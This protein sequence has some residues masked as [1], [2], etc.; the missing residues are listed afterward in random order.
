VPSFRI[1]ALTV[2][3]L[4]CFAANSLLCRA[5]LRPR[6]V[7]PATFTSVRIASGAVM[8]ALLLRVSAGPW[9]RSGG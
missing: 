6:L 5:A 9:E 1:L 3:T 8:L 7:D 4:A 2:A